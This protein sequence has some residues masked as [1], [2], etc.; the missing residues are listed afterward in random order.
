MAPAYLTYN[1]NT[2]VDLANGSD[3]QLHSLAFNSIDDK[4]I[5]NPMRCSTPFGENIDIPSPPVAIN[6]EI[7]LDYDK[8]DE[9]QRTKKQQRRGE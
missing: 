8:D 7:Y 6:V 2:E 3:I 5:V 1:L 4:K 9:S